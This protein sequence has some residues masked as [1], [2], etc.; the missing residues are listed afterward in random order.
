[1]TTYIGA[2]I[3][4]DTTINTDIYSTPKPPKTTGQIF[5]RND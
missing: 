2:V 1:M 4:I 5:P 3:N